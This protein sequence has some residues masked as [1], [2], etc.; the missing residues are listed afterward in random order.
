PM[1]SLNKDLGY[2][3]SHVKMYKDID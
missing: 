2:Q 1:I 3:V